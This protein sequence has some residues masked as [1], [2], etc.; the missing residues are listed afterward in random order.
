MTGQAGAVP[1]ISTAAGAL[2]SNATG[3]DD[4]V[5]SRRPRAE[6][7]MGLA[8]IRDGP[9]MRHDIFVMG[10]YALREV[11]SPHHQYSLIAAA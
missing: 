9:W 5:S 11:N 7:S 4:T 1:I 3:A 6:A 10:Q 2:P 8:F